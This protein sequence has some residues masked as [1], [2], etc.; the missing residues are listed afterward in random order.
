MITNYRLVE[1]HSA[2]ELERLVRELIQAGWQPRGD[3]I[4]SYP[5]IIPE[6]GAEGR[7]A[8]VMIKGT[9]DD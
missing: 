7:Y 3:T 6:Y 1:T 8:Q 9:P 5:S 4:I 2:S